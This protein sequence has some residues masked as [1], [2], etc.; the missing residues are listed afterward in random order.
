MADPSPTLGRPETKP[1]RGEGSAHGRQSA[2]CTAALILFLG[3]L[4]VGIHYPRQVTWPLAVN[5]E[6][7]RRV[8]TD[9]DPNTAKWFELAQLPGIGEA[10]AKRITDYRDGRL[11]NT[12]AI[13]PAPVVFKD[14]IDLT[15]V[16][17]VGSGTLLKIAP[18]LWFPGSVEGH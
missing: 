1:D 18:Y 2:V 11:G 17:G 6:Q 16:K 4:L 9:I 13:V 15:Q 7:V 5:G 10:T 14:P 12:K 8:R 3:T